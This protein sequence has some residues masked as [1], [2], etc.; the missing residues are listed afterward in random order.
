MVE[1]GI[2]TPRQRAGPTL[3]LTS[4]LPHD[5][6]VRMVHHPD[7]FGQKWNIQLGVTPVVPNLIKATLFGE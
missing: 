3:T 5:L 7:N 1:F 2:K 4:S 6:V